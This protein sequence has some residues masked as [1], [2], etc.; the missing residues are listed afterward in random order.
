MAAGW[1]GLRGRLA[2]PALLLVALAVVLTIWAARQSALAAPPAAAQL[3]AGGLDRPPGFVGGEVCAGCHTRESALWRDSH[4]AAAMAVPSAES[5]KGAFD[6]RSFAGPVG[7]TRFFQRDGRYVIATPGPD[8][9]V[10][11][12]PVAYSFGVYPLQQ[13][14]LALPGGRLQAFQLAWDSRPAREGGQRWFDLY[15]DR[16]A[17]NGGP[18]WTGLALN[19]NYMC[20]GCHSTALRRNLDPATLTFHSRWSDVDVAC[21]ACHGPGERHVAAA[22]AG[23]SVAGTL[24]P[25]V[26][27]GG[28]HWGGFDPMTGIRQWSGAKRGDAELTV[29][30]PCHS[31]GRP[32]SDEVAIGAPLLDGHEIELL[33]PGVYFPDGQVDD[34]AFEYGSFLQSKMHAAGV[35]CSDCHDPHGLKL[36]AEGNAVCAQCHDAARFD[37]P[38]H[39]HHPAGSSGSQ[40]IACHMPSRNFMSIHG[41]HDHSLRIPRPDLAGASDSPDA[42]TGCHSGR[43][44]Q[45]AGVQLRSWYPHLPED[46]HAGALMV[47]ARAGT[48]D[49]ALAT[50][51]ATPSANVMLRATALAELGGDPHADGLAA[52]KA[53]LAD[54]DPIV[55]LGALR[56]L[57]SAAPAVRRALLW[58]LLADPVKAIRIDAARLLAVV[59]PSSLTEAQQAALAR[60]TA[61]WVASQMLSADRPESAFNIAALRLD[62]GRDDEAEAGFRQSLRI[63]P[64]FVP[65]LLDLADLYRAQ[66][67]DDQGELLLRRAV[68]LEPANP[69]AGYALALTEIRLGKRDEAAEVLRGVLRR[70]PAYADGAYALALLD[71]AAGRLDEA[72]AV[73]DAATR[74]GAANDNLLA[75]G[76]R[77]ARARGDGVAAAR[78]EGLLK[79]SH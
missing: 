61:E 79:R 46:R 21:E 66:K 32:I 41:R 4:H 47:E 60:V 69:D 58:P 25:L 36:R 56:A 65:A 54:N 24:L 34:E 20:A 72:A 13:Y 11:D 16:K 71:E 73:V 45:W 55:R 37:T 68:S 3:D 64:S 59:P 76:A 14:L 18:F 29:C 42:C 53:G 28:G 6:G 35:T 63:D 5:I 50:L 12:F 1:T 7:T 39:S 10:Q 51:A 43:T 40:C 62:Q 23:R 49:A 15:P 30:A 44:R 9:R 38:S 22:N 17:P 31:R 75:L 8:G 52:V 27:H 48:A 19:W 78:Y 70:R 33:S 57:A 67:R 77:L 2:I 26:D 74:D